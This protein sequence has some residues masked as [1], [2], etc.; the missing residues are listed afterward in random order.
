MK[1]QFRRLVYL[2]IML[3]LVL[4][5]YG[6]VSSTKL[7]IDTQSP[8]GILP[9][10]P[11]K[12]KSTIYLPLVA[13]S[14]MEMVYIPAGEFQM[15]CDPA[16]NGGYPCEPNELP[17]RTVYLDAYYID[18]HE[19][20]NAQYAQ[21]VTVG[22]CEPPT[23]F[24]SYSRLSYYDNPTYANYP[25]IWISWYNARDY[26]LWSGKH[27]PAEAQWEKA[28]RGASDSRAFPWGDQKPNCDLANT[29]NNVTSSF[30]VGDTTQVGIYQTG[31]SP[32]GVLDMASNVL[33]WVNDWYQTDDYRVSALNEPPGSSNETYKVLRGGSW[34][35]PY[36]Y[37]R[38]ASRGVYDIPDSSYYDFGFRCAFTP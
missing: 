9:S 24:S 15:G 29:W 22:A 19:V 35:F 7:A 18:K 34:Y 13:K 1:T 3:A 31:A 32:Y 37:L 2:T 10:Y 23:K 14:E 17:M 26:C 25:V 11:T 36:N 20:T 38:V 16:H 28:A 27:L 33:E 4:P 12:R 8:H 21:C 30:C 6:E 5:L